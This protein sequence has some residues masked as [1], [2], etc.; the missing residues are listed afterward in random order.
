M[1]F[2]LE[3]NPKIFISHASKDYDYVLRIVEL[4]EDIGVK[5]RELFF[6]SLPEYG[7]R[8]GKNIYQALREEFENYNLH[9][10]YIL[11][12]NYYHSITCMNEMGAAWVLHN[13]YTTIL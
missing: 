2:N 1:R 5:E 6:S 9:V 4:L 13:K 3:K 8:G 11:S 7:I 10:L 12:D